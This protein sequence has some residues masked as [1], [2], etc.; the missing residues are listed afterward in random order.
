MDLSVIGNVCHIT[1][2]VRKIELLLVLFSQT[3]I[4][5]SIEM[6]AFNVSKSIHPLLPP[7]LPNISKAM[8]QIMYS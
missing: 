8:T 4:Y 1:K 3:C 2:V 6:I 7:I 5:D